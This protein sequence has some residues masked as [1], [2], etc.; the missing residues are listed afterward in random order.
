MLQNALEM[1]RQE[2]KMNR[3]RT[4]LLVDG[5]DPQETRKIK[6][7]LGFVDGQTTNPTLI[8]N[9]PEIKNLLASGHRLS[10]KEQ[11]DEYRKIVREIS[12][13]VGSAGVSIEV[14]SDRATKADQMFA[15][16]KEMF[17]WISNAYIKYPCTTEG[18]RAAQM[19][20]K[21]GIR[22]NLTLCFSQQQ[23][24]AV[25]GATKGTREPAYVSPFVGRLD[26]IG[27][28]GMDLI[29]NAK[30]MLDKGDGQL[31]ILSASIRSVEHLL[32]AIQLDSD[33]A[34]VPG[35]ILTEWAERGAPLPD[36]NFHYESKGTPI[37]Y[38]ELDLSQPWEKFDLHHDLTDKGIDKFTADYKKTIAEASTAKT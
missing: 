8:A 21:Q 30:H 3:P 2:A 10:E 31:L 7:N 36:A 34:T 32:Y 18:L 20:V 23:V 5:G 9:N 1:A 19:S 13:L 37:P 17:S 4:R 11:L 12:P 29:K 22:V 38:E 28:N 33:L 26:D 27:Q 24:A 14:F 15:Q 6:D 16:G 35:K 25:Y